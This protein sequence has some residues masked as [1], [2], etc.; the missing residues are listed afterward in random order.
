MNPNLGSNSNS[1]KGFW[2]VLF[3]P[4]FSHFV[5]PRVV[6]IIYF[7]LVGILG[8]ATLAGIFSVLA[9]LSTL[10]GSAFL[11]IILSPVGFLFYVILLRVML[12]SI[13]ANIRSAEYLRILAEDKF[14]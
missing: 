3:E 13:V 11:V 14:R 6:G 7:I 12:E 9:N 5:T 8:L 4:S 2:E 10:G 1:K